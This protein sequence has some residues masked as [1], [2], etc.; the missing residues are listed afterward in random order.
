MANSKENEMTAN[1]VAFVVAI[2]IVIMLTS[3]F[4]IAHT[5]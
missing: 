1:V 4:Y 3:V 2:Y 5:S